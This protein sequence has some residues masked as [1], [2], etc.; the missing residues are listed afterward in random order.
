M[1]KT[2]ELRS[3]IPIGKLS[4]GG[5][6]EYSF[7]IHDSSKL[8][9]LKSL[10]YNFNYNKYFNRIEVYINDK[11][12]HSFLHPNTIGNKSPYY[13]IKD[14]MLIY[15]CNSIRIRFQ[16]NTHDCDI[17]DFKVSVNIH[18]STP[19][20]SSNI[21]ST[22][23]PKISSLVSPVWKNSDFFNIGFNITDSP[24][25]VVFTAYDVEKGIISDEVSLYVENQMNEVICDN[26]KLGD[27]FE[28]SGNDTLIFFKCKLINPVINNIYL[29]EYHL[30]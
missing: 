30:K 2:I 25:K 29:I 12:V 14:E 17:S 20:N 9:D 28:I 1:T 6:Y 4:I 26:I 3:S 19:D 16:R 15:C 21:P 8:L 24:K 7:D 22:S 10:N 27:T 13:F 18:S 11:L 23:I 5:V